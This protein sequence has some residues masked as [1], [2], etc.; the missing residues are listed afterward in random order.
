MLEKA[1]QLEVKY[2]S[3]QVDKADQPYILHPIRAMLRVTSPK[4]RIAAIL[5][6]VV[7]DTPWTFEQ[8]LA[9]GFSE[10]IVDAVRAL[11]KQDGESRLDAAKRA[12]QNPIARVVKLAD[13]SDN[14]DLRRISNPT[15]KDFA[16][17]KEYEK[18]R[19][20]LLQAEA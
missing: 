4:A 7:E 8:L 12:A 17:L 18:V 16:R 19:D 20:L 10:D 3:G 14:M 5:H 15:A 13:V 6:D 2:H 1:I 9:E 11:T